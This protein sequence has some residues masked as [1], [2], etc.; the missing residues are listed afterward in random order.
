VVGVSLERREAFARLFS[1]LSPRLYRTALGIL[2]NPHDAG[3]ALQEAGL[4][5]FRYFG[6]LHEEEA[7]AAWLTRILINA[8]Y[9]QGRKRSRLVATGLEL[10][11]EEAAAPE[12][13]TD[14]ELVQ[15]MQQLPEEQR[16]TVTLRFFQDLTIPQIAHVMGVP[17]GT[18]KSR[19]HTALQRLRTSLTAKR[20][21]GIQ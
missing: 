11:R 20:R 10:E 16:T 21:E 15:A 17:D 19:L 1:Q 9:D 13:E 8:C 14:W 6:T 12:H 4:K 7:G 2:G 3:D 18:V 5:A